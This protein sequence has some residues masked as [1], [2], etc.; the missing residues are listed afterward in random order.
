MTKERKEN[1]YILLELLFGLVLIYVMIYPDQ[2][3]K[4]E[5]SS[6]KQT[7]DKIIV[8]TPVQNEL[9]ESPYRVMGQAR[10]GWYFEATFPIKLLDANKKEIAATTGQA[11]SDW[12]TTEFVPFQSELIFEKP[13]TD[14]GSVIFKKDNP[15]GDPKT[16]ESIEIPVRFK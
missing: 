8:F 11:L 2:K 16:D 1:F 9:I 5:I 7:N 13:K 6:I 4:N 15:S 3:T 14:T 12:M 10:G